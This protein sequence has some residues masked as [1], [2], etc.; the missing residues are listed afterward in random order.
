MRAATSRTAAACWERWRQHPPT[1]PTS[2]P[3]PGWCRWRPPPRWRPAP[4]SWPSPPHG[5]TPRP[6]GWWNGVGWRCPPTRSGWPRRWA[7][8]FRRP[9]PGPSS[10]SG[11]SRRSG[12]SGRRRSRSTAPWSAR[13]RP[14]CRSAARMTRGWSRSRRRSPCGCATTPMA[15]WRPGCPRACGSPGSWPTTPNVGTRPPARCAA[16]PPRCAAR[17]LG[18]Q[19]AGRSRARRPQGRVAVEGAGLVVPL[20]REEAEVLVDDAARRV[21]GQLKGAGVRGRVRV[22][23]ELEDARWQPCPRLAARGSAQDLPRR[24]GGRILRAPRAAAGGPAR[25]AGGGRRRDGAARPPGQRRG[26][27]V[28]ARAVRPQSARLRT[29]NVRDGLANAWQPSS[30]R[31]S[32]HRTVRWFSQ[33]GLRLHRARRRRGTTCSCISRTSPAAASAT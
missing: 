8:I 17:D 3:P 22:E 16:L 27:A 29:V 9:P 19:A 21:L 10:P 2:R 26:A 30:A 5:G 12:R 15:W 25:E 14:P 4:R 33:R 7:R 1:R 13:R 28:D 18:G 11:R 23:F 24:A 6:S 20:T 31:R 32:D